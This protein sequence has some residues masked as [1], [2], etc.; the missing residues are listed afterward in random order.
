MTFETERLILRPW[1]EDDA[2]G[3]YKYAKDPRVGPAAGWMPHKSVEDSRDIIKNVLSADETYAIVLKETML[4]IGSIGLMK[5]R[6]ECYK[7]DNELEIGYW[8]GVPYWG[9][10]IVPEAVQR[11]ISY[12]FDELQICG[13]WCGYY[14]GNDKSL[15]VQ[16]KCGFVPHHTEENV[17][18]PL[19]NEYRTEYFTYLKNG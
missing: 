14:E 7:G 16:Q 8:L 12:A 3:L 6:A 11:L 4:P 9:R 5:P 10:G 19:L 18:C 13:I 17:F 15:R 1:R 2:E